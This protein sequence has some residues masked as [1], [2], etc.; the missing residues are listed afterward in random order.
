M[1]RKLLVLLLLVT[2]G[3]SLAGCSSNDSGTVDVE[4][5]VKSEP[6]KV[7]LLL[8]GPISDMSWN[9]MGYNG[10]TRIEEEYDNVEISFVESLPKSDYEGSLRGFA[11][12]DFDIII[13]HGFSFSDSVTTVAA[14]YPDANFVV[15]GGV[16][17]GDNVT[18]VQLDNAQQGFLVGIVAGLI[19]DSGVVGAVGGMNIPPIENIVKGF[20]AGAKYVDPEIEAL[21][22]MTGNYT[23]ANQAKELAIAMID[24]GADVLLGAADAASLGIVEAAEEN[25]KYFLGINSDMRDSAP[26]TIVTAAVSDGGI[27]YTFIYDQYLAG[28]LGGDNYY[29]GIKEGALSLPDIDVEALSLSPEKLERLEDLIADLE[30]GKLNH[31]D[32]ADELSL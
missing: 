14:N 13:G 4:Q 30:Y 12:Q 19:S 18:M 24:Q 32:L 5:E 25:D 9:A 7:A 6:T 2:I 11:E 23:D 15:V 10:L 21:M 16:S 17:Q 22:A 29:V 20:A 27:M 31:Q 1:F 26:E 28:K 8:S 3:I